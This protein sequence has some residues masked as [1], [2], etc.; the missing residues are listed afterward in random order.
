MGGISVKCHRC[1]REA[2]P[3]AAPPL[4]GELG[5]EVLRSSCAACWGEWEAMEVKLINE[6]RLNFIDPESERTLHKHLREFLQ[7]EPEP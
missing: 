7:L 5:A 4:P 3:L 6:L 2:S 1:G